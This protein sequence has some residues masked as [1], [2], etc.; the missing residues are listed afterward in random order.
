MKTNY[1]FSIIFLLMLLGTG[2]QLWGQNLQQIKLTLAT[3]GQSSISI[4]ATKDSRFIVDWGDGTTEKYTGLGDESNN[5]VSCY[6][7]YA[8]NKNYD[9]TIT[10]ET[11][12]CNLIYIY[13][14]SGD[15]TNIDLSK[16]TNLKKLYCIGNKLK[17]LDISSCTALTELHCGGN[18]LTT[19]DVSKNTA[20]RVLGC[21]NNKLTTLDVRTNASLYALYCND[22]YLTDLKVTRS[23][24]NLLECYN[25]NLSM[26]LMYELSTAYSGMVN[27]GV[28]YVG[29]NTI[30]KIIG[31]EIDL[32]P[33]LLTQGTNTLIV[34]LNGNVAQKDKDYTETAGKITF[35][36]KGVFE[37]GI[38]NP[39]IRTNASYNILPKLVL[40]V[41]VDVSPTIAMMLDID[42][43]IKF[44]RPVEKTI[45]LAGT[46]NTDIIIDWGDNTTETYTQPQNGAVKNYTK[47]YANS[48]TYK[49]KIAS[50][51]NFSSLY[52]SGL[53]IS[54]IDL[55]KSTTLKEIYCSSNLFTSIDLSGCQEL[56][57]FSCPYNS[58]TSLDLSKN[59]Q[60]RNLDIS[61]GKLTSINLS[62]NI[63]LDSVYLYN[64]AIPLNELYNIS[65]VTKSFAVSNLGD[66]TLPPVT[67][68][69]NSPI[70]LSTLTTLGTSS[71]V[72]T[73][74]KEGGASNVAG[75]GVTRQNAS[76]S[77]SEDY[78]LNNGILT[79]ITPGT[80]NVT[81]T[82][83]SIVS[84]TPNKPSVKATYIKTTSTGTT[85][86]ASNVLKLYPNP[87]RDIINIETKNRT[88]PNFKLIGVQGNILLRGQGDRIDLSAYAK[89]IYLLQIDGEVFKIRKD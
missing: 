27:L 22:N 81:M 50:T 51:G 60:L 43:V 25:N 83:A 46:P 26:Q 73:V 89:G 69:N 44:N 37:I 14:Y 72:F 30:K 86:P 6:H 32:N 58:L 61:N 39:L 47:T 77:T 3:T 4:N 63:K 66:Q 67:V 40:I 65:K 28:Q 78:T 13:F 9:V 88:L 49:V 21:P 10:G 16:A 56:L 75:S 71:T 64:N 59:T 1:K 82:N 68:S 42:V 45:G 29:G 80:Y 53:D 19:L 8:T 79:L 62:N 7:R 38:T 70:D 85:N 41:L 54:S 31:D 35:L 33:Y 12:N 84:S 74:V 24:L 87:T 57:R 2:L 5:D 55:T 18:E 17:A 23:T 52:C 76:S 11:E 36:S 48:G 20:L 34:T 15:L